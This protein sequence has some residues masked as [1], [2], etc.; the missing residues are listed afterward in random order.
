MRVTAPTCS[1]VRLKLPSSVSIQDEEVDTVVSHP[2]V[3]A[4]GL[5]VKCHVGVVLVQ[6]YEYCVI[7]TLEQAVV[8][9][10]I[11]HRTLTQETWD[12]VLLRK[13]FSVDFCC[14]NI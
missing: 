9:K 14:L 7:T 3:C 12:H 5:S 2:F 1:S 6:H 10:C 4:T 11:M 13:L 8:A